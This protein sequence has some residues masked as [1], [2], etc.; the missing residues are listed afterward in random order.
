MKFSAFFLLLIIYT[1][2]L[3]AQRTPKDMEAETNLRRLNTK[4]S[5][6]NVIMAFDQ[7]YQGVK[8][9]PFLFNEW[10]N[11][12]IYFTDGKMVDSLTVKYDMVNDELITNRLDGEPWY[13][14]K[15]TVKE[16]LIEDP[17]K[18]LHLK[19]IKLEDDK[20][21]DGKYFNVFVDGSIPLLKHTKV[22]FFKADYKGGYNAN[23]PY[24]AFEPTVSWY[25]IG[26]KNK[27]VKI[28]KS[29][30]GV[31][32]L[33]P[34]HRQE[35]IKKYIKKERLLMRNEDHLIQVF[36]YFNTSEK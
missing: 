11:V 20:S 9:S 24:D 8:G 12:D 21:E 2:A 18:P 1:S 5:D 3:Q 30:K 10:A 22:E 33:F 32:Q 7:R 4:G 27:A 34:D 14:Y 26:E 23:R 13:V 31:V 6:N 28:S 25:V 36:Q 16:F 35:E 17:E 19:F 15:P 29:T